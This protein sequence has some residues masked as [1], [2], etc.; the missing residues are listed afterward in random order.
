M[1]LRSVAGD[2]DIRVSV[3]WIGTGVPLT[4]AATFRCDASASAATVSARDPQ[5]SVRREADDWH[6]LTALPASGGEPSTAK[7]R[8]DLIRRDGEPVVCDLDCVTLDGCRVLGAGGDP[9]WRFGRLRRDLV[10]A[11][12]RVEALLHPVPRRLHRG[13]G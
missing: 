9:K 7:L 4:D 1:V 12:R 6:L 11:I 10:E 13:G 8:I 5:A 2:C 3:V